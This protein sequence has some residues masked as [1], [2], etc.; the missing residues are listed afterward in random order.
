MKAS[1]KFIFAT[2]FLDALGIGLLIPVFPDV[3]RR[4]SNDAEFVNAFF[5]YFIAVYAVMQFLASPVLGALSDRYGRRP[6]L[7]V[8]LLGAGV[9][10]LLMAMAPNLTWL[11]I[12]RVISGLSGASMTVASSY[13]ADVSTDQDRSANFGLIG[14]GWGLGFIVGPALGGFLGHFGAA[15]PFIAAAVLSL[16]NFAF[17]YFVLPE[18]LPPEQRRQV[19]MAHLNP[20]TSIVKVLWPSPLMFL[21]YI[22]FLLCLAGNS[23]PSIWTL[24][25]QHRFQWTSAQV[26]L[27][28]TS[29]GLSIAFVQGWL[30]AKV[31]PWLGVE[32]T[33][34]IGIGF[35]VVGF[36][37][38]AIAPFGWMMYPILVVFSLSGV[39]MPNLQAMISRDIPANQQGELQGSL[40]SLAS[41]AAI[42]APLLY[43]KLFSAFTL[44][45]SRFYFPGMP[46]VMA[47]AICILSFAL[48]FAPRLRS[49]K[50]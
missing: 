47:S 22:F 39:A 5:G 48:L 13:M 28:L 49:P 6:V 23:H 15:T 1:A 40:I 30:T 44:G 19:R 14:A 25:T 45:P 29:V 21:V 46:Y 16:F 3:I 37:L 7:L 24:Y 11:F 17:G 20:F 26:G 31:T 10:Y 12:G 41:V 18:S 34:R 43:T 27:S 9:D 42:L 4:F 38:F 33:L 50:L 32:R 8:S 2:I 36:L 35:Y